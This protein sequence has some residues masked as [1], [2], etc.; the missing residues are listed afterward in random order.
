MDKQDEAS[1]QI[2]A[3]V[4]KLGPAYV[5]KRALFLLGW[6]CT[7]LLLV[8]GFFA[9]AEGDISFILF[10]VFVLAIEAIGA[11]YMFKTDEPGRTLIAITST[12]FAGTLGLFAATLYYSVLPALFVPFFRAPL[13]MGVLS[14]LLVWQLVGVYLLPRVQT[15]KN[16][17][18]TVALFGLPAAVMVPVGCYMQLAE[19]SSQRMKEVLAGPGFNYVGIALGIMDFMLVVVSLLAITITYPRLWHKLF[20]LK[21]S[22]PKSLDLSESVQAG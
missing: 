8:V 21:V 11:F 2:P 19:P 14:C 3:Q 22:T 1:N 7:W 13:W 20:R 18:G 12:F 15:F 10:C 9:L 16:W 4:I 17:A 6:P 5:A